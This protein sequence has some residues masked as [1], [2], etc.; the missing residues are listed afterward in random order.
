MPGSRER[1]RLKYHGK[2]GETREKMLG[3]KCIRCVS[4]YTGVLFFILAFLDFGIN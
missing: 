2:L 4:V 3:K 1:V